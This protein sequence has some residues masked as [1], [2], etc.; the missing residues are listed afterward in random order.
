M[1]YEYGKLKDPSAYIRLLRIN[2]EPS[3]QANCSMYCIS[4]DQLPPFTAVSYRWGSSPAAKTI[5]IDGMA[6]CVRNNLWDLLKKLSIGESRKIT[7]P[8]YFWIDAICI[9][10]DDIYERNSQVGLMHQIYSLATLVYIWLG[11]GCLE[12]DLAMNYMNEKVTY[13]VTSE[14]G[15]R[16]ER[17]WI[18]TPL[19]QTWE[20][21][22]IGGKILTLFNN[23]YWERLWIIQEGILAQ[24]I[25]I[26]CGCKRIPWKVLE[27][28]QENVVISAEHYPILLAGGCLISASKAGSL[29]QAKQKFMTHSTFRDLGFPLLSSLEEFSEWKCYDTRDKVYGLLAVTRANMPVDYGITVEELF[30]RV[31]R[32]VVI[33]ETD[34][35]C[36]RQKV[37]ELANNLAT[38]F[39]LPR[40][41]PW[42]SIEHLIRR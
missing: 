29:I 4:L 30:R 8:K 33:T 10:Q 12:T 23:E 11:K 18:P 6:L 22:G 24:H 17:C 28:F 39:E 5:E 14:Q 42:T 20:I 31:L 25:V 2:S 27:Y 26:L 3:F 7:E 41:N 19:P 1:N 37:R 40:P 34:R 35:F 21:S 9:N 36:T 38:C 32:Y 13:H 16:V 15:H